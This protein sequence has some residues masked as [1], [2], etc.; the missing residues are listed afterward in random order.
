MEH[1]TTTK[2]NSLTENYPHTEFEIK[3]SYSNKIKRT[4]K[5]KKGEYYINLYYTYFM[6][7]N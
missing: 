4:I 5:V 6:E 1:T 7:Y 2:R 3:S